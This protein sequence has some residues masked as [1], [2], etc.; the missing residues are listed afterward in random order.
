MSQEKS[1][2]QLAYE[3]KYE[4]RPGRYV[5]KIDSVEVSEVNPWGYS[6]FMVNMTS[7]NGKSIRAKLERTREKDHEKS[8]EIKL[9]IIDEFLSNS[10]IDTKLKKGREAIDDL[11]GRSIKCK[12]RTVKYV[13]KMKDGKPIER[14]YLGLYYTSGV[15]DEMTPLDEVKAVLE[16]NR[17]DKDKL[18]ERLAEWN[19]QN[20]GGGQRQS[21]PITPRQEEEEEDDLP[22]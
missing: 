9:K 11:V 12:F 1:E 20:S 4:T 22:F 19:M 8:K 17:Y 2:A 21:S 15:D 18:A 14:D 6:H 13:G 7:E 5:C 16:L 10:G 3:E